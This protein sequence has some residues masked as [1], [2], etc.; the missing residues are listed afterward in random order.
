MWPNVLPYKLEL[1]LRAAALQWPRIF[2]SYTPI[3]LP[4]EG[5]EDRASRDMV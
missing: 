1:H 3:L 2:L 5:T 4:I